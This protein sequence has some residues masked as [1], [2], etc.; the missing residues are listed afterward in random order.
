MAELSYDARQIL[1]L[2]TKG[3]RVYRIGSPT[4]IALERRG[5][6]R[7]SPIAS[8]VPSKEYEITAEGR[9]ALPSHPEEDS[10]G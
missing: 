4:C 7:S 9:A 2:L 6:I 5:L 8:E 1:R 3:P 10:R